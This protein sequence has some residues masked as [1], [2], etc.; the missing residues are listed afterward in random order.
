MKKIIKLAS[1]LSLSA[2]LFAS[3]SRGENDVDDKE[4][5]SN[6]AQEVT[7]SVSTFNTAIT[8]MG[9]TKQA[10]KPL[11][12]A[13]VV[14]YYYK[15][16]Q[17]NGTSFVTLSGV[18]GMITKPA[19]GDISNRLSLYLYNGRYRLTVVA[20]GESTGAPEGSAIYYSANYLTGNM[21]NSDRFFSFVDFDVEGEAVNSSITLSRIVGR[22]DVTLTARLPETVTKF[23]VK[24]STAPHQYTYSPSVSYGTTPSGTVIFTQLDAL[25]NT[26]N[27]TV[28]MY[29]FGSGVVS[30][31]MTVT[32]EAVN[33]SETATRTISGV[34]IFN[35][36]VTTLK[37][38]MFPESTAW[39]ISVDDTP[40][41]NRTPIEF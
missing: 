23:T 18:N 3:C 32:L 11:S 7:F 6:E 20:M 28:S 9:I 2:L 24:T 29:F 35:S 22:M 8:P 37:G 5:T 36:Q 12:E 25:K 14:Q 39:D 4:L 16:Y 33:G 30:P 15:V 10:V 13:G 21:F 1:L 19:D 26:D 27:G 17:W 40:W 41:E 38:K 34:T 31:G